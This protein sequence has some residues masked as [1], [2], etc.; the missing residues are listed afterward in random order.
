MQGCDLV[1]KAVAFERVKE[2][3]DFPRVHGAAGPHLEVARLRRV[4]EGQLGRLEKES[5]K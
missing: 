2:V 1:S 3:R 4:H 5:S